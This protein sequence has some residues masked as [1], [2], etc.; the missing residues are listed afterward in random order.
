MP[1]RP[2]L[3]ICEPIHTSVSVDLDCKPS[4]AAGDW[5]A[6]R[7]IP[8]SKSEHPIAGHAYRQYHRQQQKYS[9]VRR[10][11]L[12]VR[13]E[14]SLERLGCVGLKNAPRLYKH[15]AG[16]RLAVAG[17]WVRQCQSN[18]P[19]SSTIWANFGIRLYVSNLSKGW[20]RRGNQEYQGKPVQRKQRAWMVGGR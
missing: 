18:V 2:S 4:R 8:R 13:H 17:G 16:V 12:L 20:I 19:H 9:Q 3:H 14:T 10:H 6:R 7:Y 1:K 11:C 5:H 15:G